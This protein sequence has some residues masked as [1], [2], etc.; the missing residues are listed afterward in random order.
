MRFFL[1][2]DPRHQVVKYVEIAFADRRLLGDSGSFEV[3]LD[4]FQSL[5]TA[6]IVEL[7][8]CVVAEP[9]GIVIR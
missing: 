1:S 4:A 3:V 2:F 9:R 6:T 8:F 5:E 7:E